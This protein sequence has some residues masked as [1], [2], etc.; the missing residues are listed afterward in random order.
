[1][2][3]KRNHDHWNKFKHVETRRSDEDYE[4]YL[5]RLSSTVSA[6]CEKF[7][8]SRGMTSGSVDRRSKQWEKSTM[9]CPDREE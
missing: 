3:L 8:V 6:A 1:M 4:D 7:F 5:R 9:K 2:S